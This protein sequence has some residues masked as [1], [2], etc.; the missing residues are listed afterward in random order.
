MTGVFIERCSVPT[1]VAGSQSVFMIT[2]KG[3]SYEVKPLEIQSTDFIKFQ[4]LDAIDG[5]P[6]PAFELFMADERTSMEHPDTLHGGKYLM[7]NQKLVMY[8]PT[9]ELF[10]FNKKDYYVDNYDKDGDAL[11][12]SPNE[13]I[14]VFP[15]HFQTWNSEEKPKYGN[16][17]LTYDFHKDDIKVLP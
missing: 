5:Q 14:I 1:V 3:N 10:N 16:A 13:K 2:A 8:L 7:I 9:M 12:F 6:G 11:A 4:W 15:G 17:L